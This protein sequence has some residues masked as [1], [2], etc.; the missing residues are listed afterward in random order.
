MPRLF[1]LLTLFALLS[2]AA[3]AHAQDTPGW[4]AWLYVGDQKMAL[5]TSDG[6]V[7][8]EVSLPFPLGSYDFPRYIVSPGGRYVAYAGI[9]L[10]VV[11]TETG[12]VV[13]SY[14]EVSASISYNYVRYPRPFSQDETMIAFGV[15]MSNYQ[16]HTGGWELRVLN[17]QTGQEV[18]R[19]HDT[20]AAAQ[21]LDLPGF[22]FTPVIQHFA[23]DE[24][25]FILFPDGRESGPHYASYTWNIRTGQ[26]EPNAIFT[27]PLYDRL[28]TTGEVIH[29]M[30]DRRFELYPCEGECG[31]F[32]HQNTLQ[33][34]TP[35]GERFPF[36]TSPVVHFQ[37]AIFI[38]NGER[39]FGQGY[40]FDEGGAFM[41]VGRDGTLVKR[42]DI[43]ALTS[44]FGVPDGF[45]YTTSDSTSLLFWDTRSGADAPVPV[46]THERDSRPLLLWVSPVDTASS[47]YE[48]WA[49]LV[50]PE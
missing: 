6:T 30:E 49:R 24:L 34:V 43:P 20:D 46:W 44:V 3:P 26:I 48:E 13:L 39:V 23:G 15:N 25:S 37:R 7:E 17:V 41:V 21:A 22:N 40:A 19:L 5:L 11:D 32:I 38:E 36:F 10:E 16:T 27:Y 8:R 9:A 31:Q 29:P 2:L 33:V 42:L 1:L 14:D 47:Y 4:S 18:A 12:E 28:P 35:F 45:L 50:P